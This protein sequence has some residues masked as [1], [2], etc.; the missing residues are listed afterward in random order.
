MIAPSDNLTRIR[1]LDLE[2]TGISPDDAII[3]VACF[4]GVLIRPR[5]PSMS[6]ILSAERDR[7][8]KRAARHPAVIAAVDTILD[9]LERHGEEPTKAAIFESALRLGL[10]V[11]GAANIVDIVELLLR[12]GVGLILLGL[13]LALSR[14]SRRRAVP[15]LAPRLPP[16]LEGHEVP[17]GGR[18]SMRFAAA[19]N[20]CAAAARPSSST[21]RSAPRWISAAAMARRGKSRR[22]LS[23]RLA[24]SATVAD[25]SS[26]AGEVMTAGRR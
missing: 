25:A 1:V 3:E 24:I 6:S 2:T 10:T 9:D 22:L 16:P 17:T 20:T 5:N 12:A 26:S 23:I 14:P 7:S 21:S 15:R 13:A 11:V 18:S 8:L 4:D 19:R